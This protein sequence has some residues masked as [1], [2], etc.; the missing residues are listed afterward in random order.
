MKL[1]LNELAVES[2]ETAGAEKPFSTNTWDPTPAT[3]CFVC[4]APSSPEDG[5]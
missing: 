4:P 2:F 5:C 1:S 3:E